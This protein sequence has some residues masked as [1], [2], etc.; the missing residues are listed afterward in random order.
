[1]TQQQTQPFN[2]FFT[3]AVAN[4]PSETLTTASMTTKEKT[5]LLSY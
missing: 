5:T 4:S 1:M 2:P 3:V